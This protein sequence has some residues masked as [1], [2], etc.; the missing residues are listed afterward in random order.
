MGPP[1]NHRLKAEDVLHQASNLG[2]PR[3]QAISLEYLVLFLL[4][5]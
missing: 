5:Q 1:L 4:D 3:T 2:F